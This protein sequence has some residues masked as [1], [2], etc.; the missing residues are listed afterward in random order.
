MWPP[1][2][3]YSFFVAQSTAMPSGELTLE[4]TVRSQ[5]AGRHKTTMLESLELVAN[6]KQRE[7][8]LQPLFE[9]K[10]RRATEEY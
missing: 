3:Q 7:G 4:T 10:L 6:L 5:R 2:V 8:Q 9:P 1:S